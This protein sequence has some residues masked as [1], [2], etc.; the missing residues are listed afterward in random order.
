MHVFVPTSC[1]ALGT[2]W[3]PSMIAILLYSVLVV[4]LA[5]AICVGTT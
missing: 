4:V 2:I 3:H 1:N 5:R